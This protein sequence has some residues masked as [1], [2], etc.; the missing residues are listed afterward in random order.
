LLTKINHMKLYKNIKTGELITEYDFEKLNRIEKYSYQEYIISRGYAE[1]DEKSNSNESSGF[2]TS[3]IIGAA[4]NSALLGGL[5]GGDLMGGIV[6][7]LFDGDL[8]D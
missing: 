4:T 6:G 8:F 2:I 3:A 5:L 7:D 1:L